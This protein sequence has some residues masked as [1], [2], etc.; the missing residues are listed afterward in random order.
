[1]RISTSRLLL[2]SRAAPEDPPLWPASWPIGSACRRA[3]RVAANGELAPRAA[4]AVLASASR[5]R[6]ENDKKF[7]KFSLVR[8]YGSFSFH[9]SR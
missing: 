3:P 9:T 1:M 4:G 6:A 2:S 8:E 7:V 5:P